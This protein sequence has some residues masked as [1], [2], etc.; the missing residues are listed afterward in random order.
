MESSEFD[1][2][3]ESDEEIE[4][5][6]DFRLYYR[7]GTLWDSPDIPVCWLT[8]GDATEKRWVREAMLGQR[9]WVADANINLLGWGQC[10]GAETEGIQIQAGSSMVAYYLG[11]NPSGPTV[12]ELDFTASPQTKWTRCITNGLDREEC[13]KTV[14]I[15]ELGHA[16]S[17]AHEHNRPDTPAS[18]T[19]SPQGTNG[20]ATFGEWD[21]DSIMNYC[22][23]SSQL[24]GL[25]RLGAARLYGASVRDTPN[26]G[27]YDGDGRDDLLCHSSESGFKWID[28]ADASGQFL[29]TNWSRDAN[30]CDNDSQRLFT[31]DFNGDGRSDMLCHDVVSGWKWID[32]ANASGQFLGTNWSRDAD[33]C[34]NDDQQL[35]LGDFDGDGD[36]DMLCHDASSG[37]KWIDYAANGQFLGTNW[38]RD[39]TWCDNNS[40]RLHIGDFDGDGR[41]DMLCHD[42]SSGWKWID[43]ANASGQ[44]L[45]T[46]WS[47]D[48]NWCRDTSQELFI[49]DF[50]G[51]EHDDMLCHD[52]VT[53][54]KWID[55]ADASGQFLGTNWSRDAGW[56]NQPAQRLF[57]GDY[58]GDGRDDLLC[59]DVGTGT[60]WI[61]YANASGQF[62]GTNWTVAGNWCDEAENELH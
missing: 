24:S 7:T 16:L 61:D 34:D 3:E 14:S 48:A 45:G 21:S 29:G 52:A 10:T 12:L 33:W 15:H 13:I 23:P 56:C 27:D 35:H 49:G 44:F 11:Q 38:S 46:N 36:D 22:S 43:Y 58:N 31:G 50:N 2:A 53:G 39:A 30:W 54:W 17:F 60:K 20:D 51:D 62:L 25:D 47:R 57:V 55:Y 4:Q 59:H 8:P 40:Q 5:T 26:T 6:A 41:D 42:L 37:F 18:C 28:Y 32:Y 1:L 19:S 9:S